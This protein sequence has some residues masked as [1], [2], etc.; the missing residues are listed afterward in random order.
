MTQSLEHLTLDVGSGYIKTPESMIP[1]SWNQAPSQAEHGA[2]LRFS[3]S[4][5]PSLLLLAVSLSL[6]FSLSLSLTHIY[7]SISISTSILK[8]ILRQ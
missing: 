2:C 6:S 3:L 1:G 8:M 5:C 4:L 7:I